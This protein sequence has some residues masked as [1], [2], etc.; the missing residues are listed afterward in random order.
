MTPDTL[1]PLFLVGLMAGSIVL[2]G[3]LHAFFKKHERF[4]DDH[5]V[6]QYL[7]GII[8]AGLT[9]STSIWFLYIFLV[10]PLLTLRH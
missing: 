4:F 5:P 7:T 2:C 9:S 8:V 6:G 1:A 3:G 10:Y